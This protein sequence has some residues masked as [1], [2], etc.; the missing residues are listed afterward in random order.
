M[1]GGAGVDGRVEAGVA[2]RVEGV[3]GRVEEGVGGRMV[4]TECISRTK[5]GAR[6]GLEGG[7]NVTTSLWGMVGDARRS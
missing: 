5:A 7:G 3:A 4:L 2:G 1:Q 6:D